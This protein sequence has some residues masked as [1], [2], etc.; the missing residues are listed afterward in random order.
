MPVIGSLEAA[1]KLVASHVI[2][3]RADRMWRLIA[4]DDSNL[5][6]EV[7]VGF[8][9][10]LYFSCYWSSMSFVGCAKTEPA[11]VVK[12]LGGSIDH[13]GAAVSYACDKVRGVPAQ[14]LDRE[15]LE[16]CIRLWNEENPL[17]CITEEEVEEL[18][19][20]ETIEEYRLVAARISPDVPFEVMF[21]WGAQTNPE[22]VLAVAVFRRLW[23]LLEAERADGDVAGQARAS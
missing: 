18:M 17:S 22:V 20:S 23:T 16:R 3:E 4:P 19:D 13:D 21:D 15:A 9:G 11:A 5:R 7:L 6:C 10:R 14:V 1:E 8:D 2:T 12:W